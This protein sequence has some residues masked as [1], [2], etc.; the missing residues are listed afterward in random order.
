MLVS[1]LFTDN[2]DTGII[3]IVLYDSN[4]RFAVMVHATNV[5]KGNGINVYRPTNQ[6]TN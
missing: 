2:T 3:I 1:V 5:A 4:A 6:L